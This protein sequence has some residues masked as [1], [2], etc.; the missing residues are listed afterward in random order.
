VYCPIAAH[1]AMLLTLGCRIAPVI[2]PLE[3][4]DLRPRLIQ[5]YSDVETSN[6]SDRSNR[7]LFVLRIA[8]L[9]QCPYL[10]FVR[11]VENPV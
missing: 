4:C 1:R 6:D 11:C 9:D 3:E 8:S 5:C 2:L 7:V 10:Y